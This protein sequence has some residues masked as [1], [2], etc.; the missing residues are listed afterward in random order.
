MSI[1]NDRSTIALHSSSAIATWEFPTSPTTDCGNHLVLLIEG[2]VAARW[3]ANSRIFTHYHAT[4]ASKGA[5]PCHGI[6]QSL[7]GYQAP[8]LADHH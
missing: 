7:D 5:L 6:R 2:F 8:L 4:W 1:H 3:A